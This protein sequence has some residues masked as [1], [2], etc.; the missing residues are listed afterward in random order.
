VDNPF[1]SPAIISFCPGILGI[2]RGLKRAGVHPRV[3]AYVEIEAY[4]CANLVA[5]MEAGIL[6]PAP[7]WT[8]AKT[9]DAAPFRGRIHGITGGYPCT[10]FSLAGTRS[11]EDHHGHIYPAISRAIEATR[12]FWCFF[13]NVDDHLTL[14]FDK[15]YQ[16][17]QS[18]G[19]AVEAGIYTAEEVGAPH[20]RERIF[21][22]ALDNACRNR[23][24]QEYKV[25]AR[26]NGPKF[27]G[28]E[29]GNTNLPKRRADIT[30]G[31]QRNGN[32]TG[33]EEAASGSESSGEE[34]LADF[35]GQRLEGFGIR[36]GSTE[37]EFALPPGFG[38]TQ[39]P[40]RPGEQQYDWE[41]PRTIERLLGGQV[42]GNALE[43]Y[44]LLI[45]YENDKH[46][47][48]KMLLELWR[49]VKEEDVWGSFGRPWGI[50][51][52][53]ILFDVLLSRITPQKLFFYICEQ[54]TCWNAEKIQV[55][56]MR[57]EKESNSASYRPES[58]KQC[59]HEFANAMLVMSYQITL[60]R[61]QETP[62]EEI[63]RE[64]QGLWEKYKVETTNVSNALSEIQKV[65]GC[66]FN[67]EEKREA[68]FCACKEYVRELNQTLNREDLLRSFGNSVVEQTAE[69]AFIDLLKKHIKNV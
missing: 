27:T 65:W 31:Y 29:L 5:G 10:P 55:S 68:F 40:A 23:L 7:I 69:L 37:Q 12:P 61:G 22:L 47:G 6:D 41:E 15:V 54:E 34:S 13:E 17:L 67:E 45:A 38:N 1:K 44:N 52:E 62:R 8:D 11:G 3:M 21:I 60:A 33:W 59:A 9:F 39:F 43:T 18:M 50:L 28:Q 26:G 35:V 56:K 58:I 48:K 16:D 32:D 19:Y 57:C 30:P 25:S 64:M 66:E 49:I 14:G 4:I 46:N 36:A 63:F 2:E 24:Q 53:N 42:N 20:E 51:K